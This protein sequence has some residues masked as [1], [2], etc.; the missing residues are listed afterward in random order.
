MYTAQAIRVILSILAILALAPVLLNLF[1]KIMKWALTI[2]TLGLV[3]AIPKSKIPYKKTYII[4]GIA[5]LLC[6][7]AY[8]Y[9]LLSNNPYE[10]K[11]SIFAKAG[12]AVKTVMQHPMST[13]LWSTAVIAAYERDCRSVE[14]YE[15]YQKNDPGVPEYIRENSQERRSRIQA[16]EQDGLD[17]HKY[18][19]LVLATA[20]DDPERIEFEKSSQI[21]Q[22]K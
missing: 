4:I 1:I 19:L 12:H 5:L 22:N 3:W 2:P 7:P 21:K 10:G 17:K 16:F 9:V 14:Y 8:Y 13:C 18:R 6:A 15:K 20:P 11:G